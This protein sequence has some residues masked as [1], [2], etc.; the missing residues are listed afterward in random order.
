[1]SAELAAA[2]SESIRRCHDDATLYITDAFCKI[3]MSLG[4]PLPTQVLLPDEEIY[5]TFDASNIIESLAISQ[6]PEQRNRV[7]SSRKV[8]VKQ[9]TK[10]EAGGSGRFAYP[11]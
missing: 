9:G 1:M 7:R 6:E 10:A 2:H 3:A 11:A 8:E 5:S 4:S